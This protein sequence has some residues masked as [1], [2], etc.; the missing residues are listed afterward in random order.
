MSPDDTTGDVVD[1]PFFRRDPARRLGFDGLPSDGLL[2]ERAIPRADNGHKPAMYDRE[3]GL[4]APWY[5]TL[6][7]EEECY[8]A[9]RYARPL[10]LLIAEPERQ[11]DVEEVTSELNGWL[12]TQ[13]R[14][15]DIVGY[16]GDGRYVI[17]MPETRVAAARKVAKRLQH[18]VPGTMTGISAFP[19]DGQRYDRLVA[20]ALRRLQISAESAG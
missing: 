11:G 2:A 19:V 20:A 10:T 14:R 9:G 12:R 15:S 17:L 7:V 3:T 8:R 1:I 16:L 13:S 6:R 18:D 5:I 4:L